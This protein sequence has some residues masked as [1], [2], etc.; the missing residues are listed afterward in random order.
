MSSPGR[1][2]FCIHNVS[3]GVR[4][5]LEALT[6][7]AVGHD[8]FGRCRDCFDRPYL[9]VQHEGDGPEEARRTLIDSAPSQTHADLVRVVGGGVAGCPG[10]LPS[11]M[12]TLHPLPRPGQS[13]L[14]SLI[15]AGLPALTAMRRDLHA[16]PELGHAEVRTC[17]QVCAEIARLGIEHRTGIG[18]QTPG[19][20]TGVVAHLPAT[21]PRQGPSVGLRADMDALPIAER[22]GRAYASKTP[23][24]MHA[25]GHDGHTTMLLGAARVLA[26]MSHRPNPV[27]FVF[28]PA[29]EGGA[30][31]E[32]MVRDGV[33]GGAAGGQ[34][35]GLGTPVAR[36]YGLHGWPQLPL[37][38]VATR[39]GPLLAATDDFEITVRGVQAHAAYPHLG[40]DP[41]VAAAG[42]ILQLQTIASRMTSP[43]DSVVVTVGAIHA[44]TVNNVIPAECSFIGTVRTLRPETRQ[45]AEEQLRRIVEHTARAQ[46]CTAQVGWHTGYPVT[47]N[48][49]GEARRVLDL[50]AGVFGP[51]RSRLVPE[52]SMGGED[53]SYYAREVPSCFFLLGLCPPGADPRRVPQLHQPEFDFNDEAIPTGVEMFVRLA[54]S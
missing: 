29:E 4:E 40:A 24:V 7:P 14:G 34:P 8:C 26:G 21:T 45:R 33:L 36:M 51:E 20:G 53:F 2:L 38:V 47:L 18:G 3:R 27:T 13:D 48:D 16:H 1:I 39:P 19:T 17:Q 46:G 9:F 44:G 15:D 43:L 31:G 41:I 49:E 11:G 22:T 32:K 23:G 54:L 25:C 28:Q 5:E 35:G 37:G 30:G 50:A 52:P 12:T 42:I 10:P 6:P